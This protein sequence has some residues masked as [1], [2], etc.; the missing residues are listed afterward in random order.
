MAP[1]ISTVSSSPDSAG[2]SKAG[3][4]TSRKKPPLP[5]PPTASPTASGASN[6]F[7]PPHATPARGE[8][9][10]RPGRRPAV[11]LGHRHA[12]THPIR[13]NSAL[14]TLLQRLCATIPLRRRRNGVR[15]NQALVILTGEKPAD[16]E[17][18]GRSSHCPKERSHEPKAE[19]RRRAPHESGGE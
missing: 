18:P 13:P 5:R 16:E 10:S 2:R 7:S 14:V 4:C 3:S 9:P 8:G 15:N 6:R 12:L 1:E 11:L 17:E 19:A